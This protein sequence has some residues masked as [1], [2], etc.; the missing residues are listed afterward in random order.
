[1][2]GY[3]TLSR[4]PELIPCHQMQFTVIPRILHLFGGGRPYS[5]TESIVNVF[6]AFTNRTWCVKCVEYSRIACIFHGSWSFP[7]W[8]SRELL[9]NPLAI[10]LRLPQS[11]NLWSWCMFEVRT[12]QQIK[13]IYIYSNSKKTVEKCDW[14]NKNLYF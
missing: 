11:C 12:L 14:I 3:S 5:F 6:K 2:K 1:M 7:F 10:V 9:S 4:F 8:S 13:N